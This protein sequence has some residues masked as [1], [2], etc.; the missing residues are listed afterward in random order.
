MMII[1]II[2]II[3]PLFTLQQLMPMMTSQAMSG[4]HQH[5]N[6]DADA[7]ADDDQHESCLQHIFDQSTPGGA[8]E[9]IIINE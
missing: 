2:N 5:R 3:I 4:N 6:Q 9:I 8:K 7:H 1:G